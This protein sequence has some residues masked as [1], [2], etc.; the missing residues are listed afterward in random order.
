MLLKPNRLSWGGSE[1]VSSA[2]AYVEPHASSYANRTH[3]GA[4]GGDFTRALQARKHAAPLQLT[5]PACARRL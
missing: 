4:A 5:Q 3:D 1:Q 2:E